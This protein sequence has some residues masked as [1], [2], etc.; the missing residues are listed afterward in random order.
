MTD[1]AIIADKLFEACKR[2][3]LTKREASQLL[4]LG[5][6]E[7][8]SMI[9]G[10]KNRDRVPEHAWESADTWVRSHLATGETIR[11][12]SERAGCR[13]IYSKRPAAKPIDTP[14]AE[15]TQDAPKQ[16]RS[17]GKTKDSRRRYDR[18]MVI[19]DSLNELRSLGY[20][21]TITIHEAEN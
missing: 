14:E 2:E 10:T 9:C 5:A 20:A 4:G 17:S 3:G 8:A 1:K 16:G 12:Y 6:I 15:K 11:N 13:R 21:V 19:M 18:L 7:Y